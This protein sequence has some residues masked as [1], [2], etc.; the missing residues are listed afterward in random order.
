MGNSESAPT[1]DVPVDRRS[2][3]EQRSLVSLVEESDD[4]PLSSGDDWD[5]NLKIVPSSDENLSPNQDSAPPRGGIKQTSLSSPM[6]GK[7]SHRVARDPED[8]TSI[9][10]IDDNDDSHDES[11]EEEGYDDV[12][13]DDDDA[14]SATS[15]LMDASAAVFHYLTTAG[16]ED[17]GYTTATSEDVS[18][19]DRSAAVFDYLKQQASYGNEEPMRQFLQTAQAVSEVLRSEDT[20]TESP[21]AASHHYETKRMPERNKGR[22]N[23]HD[24][25]VSVSQQSAAIF[26]ALDR[27]H[28]DDDDDD[29]CDH[30]SATFPEWLETRSDLDAQSVVSEISTTIFK[31]LDETKKKVDKESVAEFSAAVSTLLESQAFGDKKK[32]R[33]DDDD[34]CS[35]SERSAAIF[36]VLDRT[37]APDVS[38][39]SNKSTRSQLAKH[40]REAHSTI[41]PTSPRM[42]DPILISFL[43]HLK[44]KTDPA[45]LMQR[46]IFHILA[47]RAKTPSIPTIKEVENEE[48]EERD[49]HGVTD[50]DEQQLRQLSKQQQ[51]RRYINRMKLARLPLFRQGVLAMKAL[52]L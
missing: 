15:A 4:D 49:D 35:I 20:P 13:S 30:H 29:P 17:S 8:D 23:V 27:A 28:D 9:D 52:P 3:Y 36:K 32:G 51:S 14:D 42:T 39:T 12:E 24:D 46:N 47:Q 11:S 43:G 25:E 5:H 38:S 2:L 45:K 40:E 44:P 37:K 1:E 48:V 6:R 41:L 22:H 21:K 31:V 16:V 18:I 10:D 19:A 26:Q 34:A 7:S 50:N 33:K